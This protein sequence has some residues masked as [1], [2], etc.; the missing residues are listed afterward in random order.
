MIAPAL[1]GFAVA[2]GVV[3]SAQAGWWLLA[4]AAALGLTWGTMT[5]GGQAAIVSRVPRDRTGAAVATH[6][7]MLDA[8]TGVGPILFGFLVPTIGYR[9]VF[10]VG[11]GLALLAL[12][13]YLRDLSTHRRRGGSARHG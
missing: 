6:F 12:P 1:L 9:G 5:T 4:G 10:W 11:A 3:A 13:V 2:M 8:G 7:F